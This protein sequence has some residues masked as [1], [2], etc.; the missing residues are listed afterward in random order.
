MGIVEGEPDHTGLASM[1]R[2]LQRLL[3]R[4][5]SGAGTTDDWGLERDGK[6]SSPESSDGKETSGTEQ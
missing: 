4:G 5:R 6:A 2:A 1:A 3:L